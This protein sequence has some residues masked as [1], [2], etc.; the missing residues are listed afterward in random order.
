[1]SFFC[2]NDP[3]LPEKIEVYSPP[4]QK[5]AWASS[6]IAKMRRRKSKRRKKKEAYFS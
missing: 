4:K 6:A 1:M 2:L 5:Y 3:R